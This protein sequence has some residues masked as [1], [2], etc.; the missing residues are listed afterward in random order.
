VLRRRLLRL[1]AK[2][3]CATWLAGAIAFTGAIPA[4]AADP[5]DVIV[6]GGTLARPIVIEG[7]DAAYLKVDL[8]SSRVAGVLDGRPYLTVRVDWTDDLYWIGRLYPASAELPA[9]ADIPTWKLYGPGTVVATCRSR[10]IGPTAWAILARHLVPLVQASPAT[11]LRSP[12]G[13][14]GA[15]GLSLVVAAWVLGVRHLVANASTIA[16]GTM[17]RHASEGEHR[18]RRPAR[19]RSR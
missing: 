5:I 12:S 2:V 14:L 3:A 19:R 13:P 8:C 16:P 6:S 17:T 4:S 10:V 15:L 7:S 11:N 1:L 18:R 9:A